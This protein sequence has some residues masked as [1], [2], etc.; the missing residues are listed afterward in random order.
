MVRLEPAHTT[1]LTFAKMVPSSQ[2]LVEGVRG[3]IQRITAAHVEKKVCKIKLAI[4]IFLLR[5]F[6]KIIFH[7]LVYFYDV[8]IN[9]YFS[10]GELW[11]EEATDKYCP[12]ND[13]FTGVSTQ[14]ECQIKCDAISVCPGISYSRKAGQSHCYVCRDDV[15]SPAGSSYGFYRKGNSKF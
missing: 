3:I 6:P 7:I 2:D 14:T 11:E 4:S 15:L 12:N 13:V 5:K 1:Y 9:I 8:S 10:K